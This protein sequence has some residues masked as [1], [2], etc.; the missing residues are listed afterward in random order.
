MSNKSHFSLLVSA[1]PYL[2]VIYFGLLYNYFITYRVG[3][4]L[5]EMRQTID[6][7]R[8]NGKIPC[9]L[10]VTFLTFIVTFLT[11]NGWVIMTFLTIIGDLLNY[12]VT[13]LTMPEIPEKTSRL[14]EKTFDPFPDRPL[15]RRKEQLLFLL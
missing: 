13:F 5:T 12:K 3:K 10:S 4:R 2:N 14:M 9:A 1:F 15:R 8:H 6:K 7:S 11:I